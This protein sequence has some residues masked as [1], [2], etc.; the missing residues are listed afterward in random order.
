MPTADVDESPD[1]SIRSEVGVDGPSLASWLVPSSDR[2]Q[3]KKRR[4]NKPPKSENRAS[5][6]LQAAKEAFPVQQW[7]PWATA[8][9]KRSG[10][11]SE[12]GGGSGG[13]GDDGGGG[14]GGGGRLSAWLDPCVEPARGKK[15][16]KS[17]G[18]KGKVGDVVQRPSGR[19][20][21]EDG[22][23]SKWMSQRLGGLDPSGEARYSTSTG[24]ARA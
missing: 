22:D 21:Q 5:L 3:G 4:K 20:D 18:G 23:S 17:A 6:H 15:R 10:E 14:G 13:D 24:D 16:V 12:D 7:G 11:T 9:R 8:S 2:P 1:V 19:S